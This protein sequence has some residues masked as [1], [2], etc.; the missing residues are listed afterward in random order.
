V[1]RGYW[2]DEA[3]TAASFVVHP[4]TGERLYRTGDR[5]RLLPDGNIEFL[6]RQDLQ[7]KIRGYRIEL[8]EIEACLA[9]HP[10]V[11]EVLVMARADGAGGKS[12]VAYVTGTDPAPD[13]E[14]LRAFLRAKLPDYMLPEAYV[15]L[16]GLPL[17]ANG[18]ID[19]KA[20]PAP[21]AV[22]AARRVFEAPQSDTE[23]ALAAIWCELLQ[24]DRVGRQDHFFEL[25]GNS[26]L[27]V[28][29][30]ARI[31]GSLGVELPLREIFAE[32]EL[33]PLAEKILDRQV[34]AFDPEELLEIARQAGMQQ[35]GEELR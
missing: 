18:K 30:V 6:G 25:G 32:P 31:R 35:R 22:A 33:A 2:R 23:Q 28:Q 17:T 34:G 21:Q 29:C 11:K 20:L 12:L 7:V 13:A 15:L 26:L 3:K 1:A 16:D 9:Q 10:R 8:G 5:G 19:A 14:D 24:V 27:A 4:A